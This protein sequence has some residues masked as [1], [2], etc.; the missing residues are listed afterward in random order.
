[1]VRQL[2]PKQARTWVA[3]LAVFIAGGAILWHVLACR[4]GKMAFSPDGRRLV[5]TTIDPAESEEND[6]TLRGAARY[7]LCVLD[8]DDDVRVIE[9][10][11][12]AM[13]VGPSFSPDG[14][15]IAYLRVLLMTKEDHERLTE[16]VKSRKDPFKTETF[17]W[18]DMPTTQPANGSPAD[19]A[20]PRTDVIQEFIARRTIDAPLPAELIIRDAATHAVVHAWPVPLYLGPEPVQDLLIAYLATQVQYDATGQCVYLTACATSETVDVT[21]GERR[22]LGVGPA[23]AR[24]SPD[25]RTLAMQTKDSIAFAAVDGSRTIYVHL[26]GETQLDSLAWLDNETLLALHAYNETQPDGNESG[27]MHLRSVPR[28]GTIG[29]PIALPKAMHEPGE[30][31]IDLAI[32]PKGR[33]MALSRKDE[34]FFM[35]TD[36]TVI[37]ELE[38]KEQSLASPTFSPD[39]RRIA[40][41]LVKNDHDQANRTEAIV[42]FTPRGEELRRIAVPK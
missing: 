17:A 37:K 13:L 7:R 34:T 33:Y 40:F 39:G 24:L 2:N 26:E 30:H 16:H 42:F 11:T 25:G 1:M 31:A 28:D 21:T 29:E 14:K 22:I 9:E 19:F 41:K 38:T 27:V 3:Y 15:Q 35:T 4:Q 5:F 32:G 20:L 8:G 23:T 12:D 6:L 18:K 10:T 36:G